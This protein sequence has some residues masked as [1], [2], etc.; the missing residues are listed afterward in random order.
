VIDPAPCPCIPRSVAGLGCARRRPAV[1]TERRRGRGKTA[2]AGQG[3][4]LCGVWVGSRLR[5]C[6]T[7]LNHPC[8]ST[9]PAPTPQALVPTYEAFF[10]KY[11]GK[12][13]TSDHRKHERYSPADVQA[14]VGDLFEGADGAGAG[15]LVGRSPSKSPGSMSGGSLARRLS[16]RGFTP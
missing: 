11:S 5:T 4:L 7:H 15:G 10:S 3:G 9:A 12:P 8:S 14:L 1:C 6:P 16:G 2:T 13:Y